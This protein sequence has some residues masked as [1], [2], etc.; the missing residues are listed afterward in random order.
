MATTGS[1]LLQV[2]YL[3]AS[4]G[5]KGVGTLPQRFSEDA[6]HL[7]PKVD[8][9]KAWVQKIKTHCFNPCNKRPGLLSPQTSEDFE[10]LQNI[11]CLVHFLSVGGEI[12]T[13]ALGIVRRGQCRQCRWVRNGGT[14]DG[15][16]RIFPR[17][18]LVMVGSEALVLSRAIQAILVAP[19]SHFPTEEVRSRKFLFMDHKIS[20]YTSI[21]PTADRRVSLPLFDYIKLWASLCSWVSMI[22]AEARLSGA[23][24]FG[25]PQREQ[26][27]DSVI[28]ILFILGWWGIWGNFPAW[29]WIYTLNFTW[30]DPKFIAQT[31]ITM[32][33]F[34]N[35]T[36]HS[37]FNWSLEKG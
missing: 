15:G 24:V 4:M 37:P 1:L 19:W 12:E 30:L 18:L 32:S 17:R 33:K 29:G 25:W 23:G 6:V 2:P 13:N 9:G 14:Q 7:W 16:G 35:K 27:Q 20:S 21:R 3:L 26:G 8:L 5:G 10:I 28:C 31:L 22:P 11:L 36:R 34:W